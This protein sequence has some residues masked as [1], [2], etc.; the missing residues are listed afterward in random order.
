MTGRTATLIGATGLI[1]SHLLTLLQNDDYYDVVR[2]L[3]RRPFPHQNPKTEAKLID[4]ADHESFRLAVEGS[5]TVFCAI[6][7]TQQKVKGD[8]EAYRKVD[9][10]IPVKAA[11]FAM[12]AG[13]SHFSLVS[14]VGA[15]IKSGTFYLKLK[16]E[17][18]EDVKKSGV[19]GIALFRPSMLMGDRKEFRLGE[20]IGQKVMGIFGFTLFGRLR[21][22]KPIHA[23]KVAAAMLAAAKENRP[24]AH[25]YEYDDI[26]RLAAQG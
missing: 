16:G 1:G 8:K 5:H 14:S 19:A 11:K 22:L 21:K 20:S 25:T 6:G 4:F 26:I 10:D 9:Y 18:E 15:D 17:V 24:G 2:V 3:V 7:T 12:E 13:S 23:G